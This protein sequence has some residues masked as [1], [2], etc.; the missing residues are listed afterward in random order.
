MSRLSA[1][2]AAAET[3][4]TRLLEVLVARSYQR[5]DDDRFELA[6]GRRS[7]FY[8]DCKATTMRGEAMPLI[9]HLVAALIPADIESVG[10]LTMGA[11]PIALVTACWCTQAHRTM[12]AFTVR[13]EPKGHGLMKY[14]EGCPGPTVAVVDDVVTTGGSTIKAI[15]KCREAGIR[16]GAV[17]VLVDRQEGGMQEV[18]AAVGPAV[19]VRSV[20][21]RADLERQWRAVQA[22]GDS[23]SSRPRASHG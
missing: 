20:F 17:V 14:I 5:A 3:A 11:D 1:P 23:V 22:D 19:P 12:N 18:R 21:T 13:K 2:P 16:V 4:W 7:N 6:S 15:Q 9:G 8:I 10:G